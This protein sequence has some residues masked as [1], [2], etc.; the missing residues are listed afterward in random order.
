MPHEECPLRQ[1]KT[2]LLARQIKQEIEQIKAEGELA[3][4]GAW[5][6]RFRAKGDFGAYWYFKWQS[7]SAIF[8]AERTGKPAKTK[9]IGKAGSSEY[10]DALLMQLRRAKIEALEQAFHTLSLGLDD[11]ALEAEQGTTRD[12]RYHVPAQ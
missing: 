11:L 7:K 5:I 4:T 8:T 10:I 6:I 3:P 2:A 9:Y 12:N 1:E